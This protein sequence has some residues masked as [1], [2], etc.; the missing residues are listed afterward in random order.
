MKWTELMY[1]N[2]GKGGKEG[3]GEALFRLPYATNLADTM[4]LSPA[5]QD[6]TE[7]IWPARLKGSYT[8]L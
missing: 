7:E 1:P 8:Q 2:N 4:V 6:L 3:G 5:D